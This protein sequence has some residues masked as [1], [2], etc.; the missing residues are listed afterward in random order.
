MGECSGKGEKFPELHQWLCT[1]TGWTEACCP[2]ASQNYLQLI[3]SRCREL[4]D[5][6]GPSQNGPTS[7]MRRLLTLGW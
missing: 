7:L 1:I 2:Q 3:A 6:S 4:S 5:L